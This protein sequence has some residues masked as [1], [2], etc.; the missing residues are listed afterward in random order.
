MLEQWAREIENSDDDD[1]QQHDHRE[2]QAW[3]YPME[4]DLA[5]LDMADNFDRANEWFERLMASTSAA[6]S[7]KTFVLHMI[8]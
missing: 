3:E 6:D 5:Q 8:F 1:E 7:G 2:N 4:L